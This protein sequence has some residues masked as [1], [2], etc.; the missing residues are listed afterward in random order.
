MTKRPLE[1]WTAER[2]AELYGIRNWSG[3]Y[4]DV[5]ENGDLVLVPAPGNGVRVSVPQIIDGLKERGLELPVL[6]RVE[7]ILDSQ[8]SL[9]HETFRTAIAALGYRGEY[10]G[11]FPVKVNQQQQVVEEIAQFGSR[12]HHGLEV[13]SK[14]ELIAALAYLSDREACLV[15]NGYKDSDFV[16]LALYA[17]KMGFNCFLV[18]E[19]PGEVQLI[20]E[21]SKALGV[22]PKMGVRTKVSAQVGGHWA[23]S[24]GDLSIF[25]LSTAEVVDVVDI[26]RAE[27]MLDCLRL[28][29]FHL[30][31]Q[32]PNIRDIRT[33]VHEACRMYAELV[34]EGCAMGYLDLGGGLAVDYDGSHTNFESSRNYTLDEYCADIVE[35]VMSEMDE[36]D[37][38]HPH[39]VTESGR[40]T[41]A[42]YSVLL[43]DVLDESRLES[44]PVPAAVPEDYP[45]PVHNLWETHRSLT[46]KNVQECYNDAIYYRDEVRQ[47]FRLGRCSL[48]ERAMG[49]TIFWAIM[50][51][52]AD[53]LEDV[54]NPP[55]WMED[56]AVS[57]ASIYYCNMS[58]FQSLPDAWAI[59]HLFPIMPVHRLNEQPTE[60]AF[61]ADITCDCDGKIDRFIDTRGVKRVLELH[62]LEDDRPY[63][64]GA[65]L[66]GAYQETLGDLHNLFGDTNVVSV[67][68]NPDGTFDIVRELEGDSVSDVLSYVEYDPKHVVES[69]RLM[70]EQGVRDG[71]ITPQERYYIMKAYERCMRGYTYLYR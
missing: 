23:E 2:S 13:G 37:M 21:R 69:F 52:I 59:D 67:R 15:C 40:A 19:M 20:L 50:R 48:R 4:F 45:E 51:N 43:F 66:V 10:R 34:G 68:I 17:T 33:A 36:R 53:K 55:R 29:H 41:V 6:L 57:L 56:I 63:Y 35:T 11:V 31:S 42:Y 24:A 28:L 71:N 46:V 5:A 27:D 9:L 58:V 30:G 25:G 44:R 7:N 3:G 16:D 1:K 32:I 39:I 62:A 38:P 49:E 12:Y 26:L 65:F 60:Q 14:A 22:R 8:I 54:K 61:L 70:A 18:M 64:L 47:M